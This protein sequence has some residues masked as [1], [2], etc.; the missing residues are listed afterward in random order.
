VRYLAEE[1]DVVYSECLEQ[2]SLPLLQKIAQP[3]DYDDDILFFLSSILKKKKATSQLFSQI[4][5]Y[6]PGVH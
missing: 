4:L 3:I 1:P 2:V 6:L 5:Q